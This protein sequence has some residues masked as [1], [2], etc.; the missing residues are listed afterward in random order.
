MKGNKMRFCIEI[1]TLNIFVEI[2][3]AISFYLW[4][5]ERYDI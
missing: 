1:D 5:N 4:Y 3:V 2:N